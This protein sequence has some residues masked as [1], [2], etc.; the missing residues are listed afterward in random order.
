MPLIIPGV[1]SGGL[2]AFITSFDEV[3][4]V[5]FLA[6]PEQRTIPG[7]CGQDPRTNQPNDS[8]GGNIA[9]I[10]VDYFAHCS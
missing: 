10:F 9:G 7:K 2:F 3:V 8:G 4:A 5:L 6:S 1:V